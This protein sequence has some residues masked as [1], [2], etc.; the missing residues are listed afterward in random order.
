VHV[1]G[2]GDRIAGLCQ[3]GGMG[4]GGTR[5]LVLLRHA[6]SAWPEEVADRERPLAGRGR[7]DAPAVGRWLRR[8][9]YV[10]DMVLCSTARRA[11]E[12]WELVAGE[13][14]GKPPVSYEPR[15]YEASTLALLQLVREAG[16]LHATLLLVGHNPAIAEFAAGLAAPCSG[17]A[18]RSLE[19]ARAKF[20]TAAVAVLEFTGD[21]AGLT[22]GGARMTDFVTPR[23]MRR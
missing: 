2:R 6:K 3:A 19:R 13:L 10:P 5:R 22:P 7:R 1:Q 20:P 21:W 15:I 8:A 12:T 23:G 17:P 14:D 11:R 18:G 9:G 4:A 16:G